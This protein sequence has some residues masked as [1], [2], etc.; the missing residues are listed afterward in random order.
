MPPMDMA[1]LMR[2]PHEVN[3]KTKKFRQLRKEGNMRGGLLYERTH[4]LIVR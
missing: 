3:P 1:N 2:K 4:K